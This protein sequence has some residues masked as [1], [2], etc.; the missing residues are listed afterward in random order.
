MKVSKALVLTLLVAFSAAPAL[1][2]A[3]PIPEVQMVDHKPWH[4]DGP[5][6]KGNDG[7]QWQ[8]K[9]PPKWQQQKWSDCHRSPDRHFVKGYGKVLHR[10]VGPNCRVQP[11]KQYKQ[12]QN[13]NCIRL[14][15]FW[16]CP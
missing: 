5:Q 7:P 16:I 3:T 15:D 11:V 14:G 6:W 13:N 2:A 8:K 12:R 1:A 10:H 9:A 4:D